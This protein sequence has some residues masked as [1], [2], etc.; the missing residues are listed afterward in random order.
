METPPVSATP[1]APSGVS[2]KKVMLIILGVF[3]FT[4]LG[5]VGIGYWWYKHNFDPRPMQPVVL[6]DKEQTDLES[7]LA[8]FVD[9]PMPPVVIQ[10]PAEPVLVGNLPVPQGGVPPLLLLDDALSELD[11]DRRR[12]LSERVGAIGQTLVTATGAEALPLAPAQLLAVTPGEVH[13]G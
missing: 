4:V 7:K 2:T 10:S 12:R 9:P 3:L 8:I 6:S 5:T 11:A 1:A 13:R